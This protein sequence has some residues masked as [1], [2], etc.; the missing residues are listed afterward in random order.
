MTF[1]FQFRNDYQSQTLLHEFANAAH[2]LLRA[3]SRTLRAAFLRGN[4]VNGVHFDAVQNLN[5]CCPNTM[6]SKRWTGYSH[7]VDQPSVIVLV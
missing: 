2:N 4:A 5:P 6:L 1:D 7:R 3:S